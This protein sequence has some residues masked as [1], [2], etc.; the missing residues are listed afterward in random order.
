MKKVYLLCA[1]AML[2]VMSVG[3]VF[4]GGGGQQ[5]NQPGAPVSS[6]V[7]T[8]K[9]SLPDY[10]APFPQR[11][12]ITGGKTLQADIRFREGESVNNSE[13]T[14]AWRDK[15]NVNV[16]FTIVASTEADYNTLLNLA[17][18]SRNAPDLFHINFNRYNELAESNFLA[19]M[20]NAYDEWCPPIVKNRI[21]SN[22]GVIPSV[23]I[24]GKMYGVPNVVGGA[25][26]VFYSRK[27]WVENVGFKRDDM[28]TI[29]DFIK[30]CYAFAEKD[31]DRNGRRDTYGFAL[32]SDLTGFYRLANAYNA[33]PNLWVEHNGRIVYGLTLPETKEALAV[34]VQMFKDGIIDPEFGVK[35]GNDVKM[36]CAAGRIGQ[37]LSDTNNIGFFNTLQPNKNDLELMI[38]RLPD[39]TGKTALGPTNATPSTIYVSKADNRYPEAYVKMMAFWE[40]MVNG[41]DPANAAIFHTQAAADGASYF[42]FHQGF[43]FLHDGLSKNHLLSNLMVPALLVDDRSKNFSG[44]YAGQIGMM[45]DN[46]WRYWADPTYTA[47]WQNRWGFGP[48]GLNQSADPILVERD[49]LFKVSAFNKV[50]GQA[51][52][53]L[54]PSLDAF[55]DEFITKIIYGEIPLADY[56][57]YVDQWLRMGGQTVT[58]EIN[59]NR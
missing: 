3:S 36:D 54:M 23:T 44:P 31:P 49:K 24:N 16:E 12:N 9:T 28:K 15:L 22:P 37:I 47:G 40:D 5:Q 51:M 38:W 42:V 11:I 59:R 45:M 48:E 58:D 20:T 26:N 13:W 30:L 17:I 53:D 35:S 1:I 33:W 56:D 8:V 52:I 50:P 10:Y 41:E 29:D 21:E 34:T 57:R 19:D 6:G 55:R 27:D 25:M 32:S 39:K 46:I 7:R 2:F 43:M 18:A 4:A 14:R